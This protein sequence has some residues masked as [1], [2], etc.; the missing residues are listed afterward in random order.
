MNT[1]HLAI[2]E[3]LCNNINKLLTP[4]SPEYLYSAAVAQLWMFGTA[5]EKN[6]YNTFSQRIYKEL[7]TKLNIH[8]TVKGHTDINKCRLEAN[9]FIQSLN[10]NYEQAVN[11]H[12]ITNAIKILTTKLTYSEN[13]VIH[14]MS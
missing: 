11:N 4:N 10:T 5:F 1:D 14:N 6:L 2:L 13:E 9:T 3:K 7:V 8:I 12:F